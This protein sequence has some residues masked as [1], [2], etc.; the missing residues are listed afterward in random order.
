MF[1]DVT[2]HLVYQMKNAP[3]QQHPYPH[4]YATGIFPDDFYTEILKHLP[5]GDTYQSLLARGQIGVVPAPVGDDQKIYEQQRQ[6]RQIQDVYE[7]RQVIA[8]RSASKAAGN[9][10]NEIEVGK[11]SFWIELTKTL[12]S[13]EFCT[14]LVRAFQPWFAA[15]F[16]EGVE[17]NTGVQIDLNRDSERWALGPH[18]DAWP[19]IAVIL[20]YL[21]TDDT[22]PHLGTSIYTPKDPAFTCKGGPHHDRELFNCA[23]F[24][25]YVRNSAFAFF[26]NDRSFH[27]VEAMKKPG[28]VKYSIQLSIIRAI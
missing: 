26:K 13:P 22:T 24:A 4:F 2:A 14:N 5:V 12:S 3:I 1:S 15:R 28:E 21:P 6:I 16:G 10:V 20:F 18:T 9:H 25:P 7:Q 11:R 17:L 8:L 19:T 23:Y 27:G